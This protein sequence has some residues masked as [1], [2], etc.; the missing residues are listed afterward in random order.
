M[1]QTRVTAVNLNF[2]GGFLG[3]V[4]G[5]YVSL[6]TVSSTPAKIARLALQNA[7]MQW[8]RG[9]VIGPVARIG[10]RA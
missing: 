9:F 4:T 5:I 10:W 6:E 7:S 2:M 1:A 8:R 3:T